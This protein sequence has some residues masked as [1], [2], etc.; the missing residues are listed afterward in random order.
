[1]SRQM[2][3]RVS[4]PASDPASGPGSGRECRSH[5]GWTWRVWRKTQG[6]A[7]SSG[8][9]VKAINPLVHR[10]VPSLVASVSHPSSTT[11]TCVVHRQQPHPTR[12]RIRHYPYPPCLPYLQHPLRRR[13]P[14]RPQGSCLLPSAFP[15]AAARGHT[16]SIRARQPAT[17]QRTQHITGKEEVTVAKRIWSFVSIS[18]FLSRPLSSLLS[19]AVSLPISP[20]LCQSLSLS[21]S[22][23]LSLS[24]PLPLHRPCPRN[25]Q[26]APSEREAWPYEDAAR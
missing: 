14:R 5:P 12:R 19:V 1:M 17:T 16:S 9:E 7:R 6:Y 23:S 13:S 11:D 2:S 21:L 20:S 3:H 8:L 15:K 22:F 10:T 4:I 18:V 25:V 26:C 24:L